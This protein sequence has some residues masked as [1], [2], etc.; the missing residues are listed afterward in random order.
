MGGGVGVNLRSGVR[1]AGS[2]VRPGPAAVHGD[3][4]LGLFNMTNSE[5]NHPCTVSTLDGPLTPDR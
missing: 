3:P 5:A 1:G 2:E 4:L